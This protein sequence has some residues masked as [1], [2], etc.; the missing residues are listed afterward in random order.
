MANNREAE[1]TRRVKAASCRQRQRGLVRFK[2]LLCVYLS[3]TKYQI[4]LIPLRP[5]E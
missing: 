2:Q 3:S 5:V 4:G 1:L